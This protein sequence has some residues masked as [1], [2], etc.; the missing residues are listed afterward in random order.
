MMPW[1]AP[2][3]ILAAGAVGGVVNL[4]MNGSGGIELGGMRGDAEGHTVWRPGSIATPCVGAVAAL[5]SWALYGR[6]RVFRS[7]AP[8]PTWSMVGYRRGDPDWVGGSA[9]LSAEVDKS[10]LRKAAAT[11]AQSNSDPALAA[12]I[13]A[14]TPIQALNAAVAAKK[15]SN[16]AASL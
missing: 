4:L 5:V 2:V 9:W 15:A 14:G 13:T 3:A 12:T 7:A 6:L 10:I 16:A 1:I 11:A 8:H